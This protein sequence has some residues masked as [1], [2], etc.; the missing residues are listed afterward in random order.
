MQEMENSWAGND[1]TLIAQEC[2][3]QGVRTVRMCAC[4]R[5]YDGSHEPCLPRRPTARHRP[6]EIFTCP[7]PLHA[8]LSSITGQISN[9]EFS[10]RSKSDFEMFEVSPSSSNILLRSALAWIFILG[11][12]QNDPFYFIF[13]IRRTN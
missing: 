12:N 5:A 6:Q 10:K 1:P 11:K 7:H 9:Q 2:V 13:S 8:R 4:G 3:S